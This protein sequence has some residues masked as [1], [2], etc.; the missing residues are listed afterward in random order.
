MP[1]I[2]IAVQ[3]FIFSVIVPLGVKLLYGLG[4][5]VV[6]YV[7]IDFLFDNAETELLNHFDGLSTDLYAIL[8]IAGVRDGIQV[9]MASASTFLGIKSLGGFTKWKASKPSS[10]VA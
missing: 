8:V 7:G 5:A 1:A 9:M 3:V 4:F 6:T 2:W 10:I